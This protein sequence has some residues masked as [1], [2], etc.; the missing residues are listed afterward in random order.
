MT[1]TLEEKSLALQGEL[2]AFQAAAAETHAGLDSKQQDLVAVVKELRTME[3]CTQSI[4]A[5]PQADAY[6]QRGL[7]HHRLEDWVEAIRD[8]TEAIRL[9]GELAGAFHFR[10]LAYGALDNRKQ[11]TD[12]LRQAYKLY[13]DQGDL[14]NYELAR[15]LHKRFYEGPVEN[16]EPELTGAATN[17]NGHETYVNDE[18]DREIKPLLDQES[19]TTAANLFG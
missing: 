19:E 17:G 14:D 9:N 1:Q 4:A 2:G 15:S 10:G 7:S 11:A 18:P 12:D 5:Y 3:G 8:F 6:Y 16:L 13:F